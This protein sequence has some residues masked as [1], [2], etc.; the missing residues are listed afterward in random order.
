MKIVENFLPQDL[1]NK[2]QDLIIVNDFPWFLRT[3]M[4]SLSP[5]EE[6]TDLGYFTHS[7]YNQN[8]INSSYYQDYIL[9]ILRSAS[10][11]PTSLY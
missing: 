7:F 1:L 9:P 10:S 4:V 5:D 6:S 3:S 2:L 8:K 11:S